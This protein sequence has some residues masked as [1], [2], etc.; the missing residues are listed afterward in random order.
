MDSSV[1]IDQDYLKEMLLH[2]LR[3]HS[4]TG[5][6]DPIV[7]EVCSE[8]TDLG[9]D[10]ELTRRGAI[11]STLPGKKGSPD[12]AI[13]AHLDTLGAMVAG[14]KENGRLRIVPVGTWSARFAEGAR[15]SI[16]TDN[17]II[18]GTVLPL[19][20]SGHIFNTE[21]DTQPCSWDNLEIRVDAHI[22][23]IE[24][25]RKMGI[26]VG[27]FVGVDSMAECMPNGYINARHLDDKAGVAALLAAVRYLKQND[28]ELPVDL[29]ILFT[30]SEEVGSGA[31]AV[32]HGDVAE[33]VSI[34]N[35]TC[36]PGQNSSEFGVTV[37]VGD[38]TG[39]FDYHLTHHLLHLCQNGKIPHQRDIFRYYR[40]DSAS[41]LDAGND[42][43]TALITFGVDA[44]HGYER[45]N[46]HS[47]ECIARLIV[48]YARSEM[49]FERQ[50][51]SLGGLQAFPETRRVG[52][53]SVVQE[54][55]ERIVQETPE[56]V[57]PEEDEE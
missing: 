38:S 17:T 57:I 14:L 26:N 6:T 35:G 41:A 19:K 9:I 53:D 21:V 31:S 22:E 56:A 16:F 51:D 33:M 25:L 48:S 40:C 11:R 52:V 23:G 10:F 15:V 24:D 42:I 50:K 36:G 46:L 44:S 49:I 34:D 8:L 30:I 1:D 39:P 13:I 32:L 55:S 47:L 18:R 28:I 7:R 27:D 45:T 2:L 29:H 5:Y 4:P 54:E 3:I 12:R 37:A 20:A 43:R